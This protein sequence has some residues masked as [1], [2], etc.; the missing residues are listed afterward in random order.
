MIAVLY[1]Q[2]LYSDYAVHQYVCPSVTTVFFLHN[3]SQPVDIIT[4]ITF[5]AICFIQILD[6]SNVYFILDHFIIFDY[7][8]I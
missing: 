2:E 3:S 6:L 7:N 4:E 5:Y 8:L 1:Q